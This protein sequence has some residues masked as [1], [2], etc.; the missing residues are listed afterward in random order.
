MGKTP[1]SARETGS[2]EPGL[3]KRSQAAELEHAAAQEKQEKKEEAQ[4]FSYITGENK[5]TAEHLIEHG[6]A[7]AVAFGVQ[8]LA[9]PDLPRRFKLG[10]SLNEPDPSTFYT[11][12][13]KGY[14]DY[15]T[16]A[17]VLV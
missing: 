15:P 9:N 17:E 10:L 1:S 6:E 5:E 12:G 7:D 2:A 14:T 13:P 8:F 3:P 4:L 11:P 16:L